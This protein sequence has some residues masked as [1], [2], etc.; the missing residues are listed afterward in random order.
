VLENSPIEDL[1]ESLQFEIELS[2]F[3]EELHGTEDILHRGDSAATHYLR[4]QCW[5]GKVS[6]VPI[7]AHFTNWV[8]LYIIEEE[9]TWQCKNCLRDNHFYD[10]CELTPCS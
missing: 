4:I 7:C 9:E 5:C 6:V 8:K 3:Q 1:F 10:S 2:C